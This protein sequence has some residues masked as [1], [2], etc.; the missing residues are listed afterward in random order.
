MVIHMFVYHFA[1]PYDPYLG[2]VIFFKKE[3]ATE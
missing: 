1:D 2:I 3:E